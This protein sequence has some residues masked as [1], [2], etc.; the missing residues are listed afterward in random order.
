MKLRFVRFARR[1]PRALASA[2]AAAV[3]LASAGGVVS[4]RETVVVGAGSEMVVDGAV[5]VSSRTLL[6]AAESNLFRIERG[7][8]LVLRNL[9]ITGKNLEPS[10][11]RLAAIFNRGTLVCSNVLFTALSSPNGAGAAYQDRAGAKA[12]FF[13]CS[14]IGNSAADGGAVF[15]ESGD[16]TCVNC[17]FA[18]NH[19][20]NGDG[21]RGGSAAAAIDGAQ[22]RLADCTVTA[23]ES[24]STNGTAM[25]YY[26]ANG[27]LGNSIVA[28]NGPDGY[29][30]VSE[31]EEPV[32]T[33]PFVEGDDFEIVKDRLCLGSTINTARQS[34]TGE[35]CPVSSTVVYLGSRREYT[36]VGVKH[37]WYPPVGDAKRMGVELYADGDYAVVSSDGTGLPI[38]IDTDIFDC[39][40]AVAYMGARRYNALQNMID[41]TPPGGICTVPADVYD[42]AIVGADKTGIVI[43]GAGSASCV[44]NGENAD[45]CLT[46]LA[47][48]VFIGGFN[49]RNGKGDSG[50]GVKS[51]STLGTVVSNCTF[52]GDCADVSG[53][54]VSGV[55][56]VYDSSFTQCEALQNGGGA[57]DVGDVRGC[58]FANCLAGIGGGGLSGAL[59]VAD[60]TFEYCRA[61]NAVSTGGGA[62][63]GANSMGVYTRCVFTECSANDGGALANV[64]EA[65]KCSF[66]KNTASNQGGGV[67]G[68]GTVADGSFLRNVATGGGGAAFCVRIEDSVFDSNGA[69]ENGGG[70]YS[71]DVVKHSTYISNVAAK[72]GGGAYGAGSLEGCV[73]RGNSSVNG[74]G[75][76]NLSQVVGTVFSKNAAT[77]AGGAGSGDAVYR[78]CTFYYNSANSVSVEP[79]S[80]LSGGSCTDSLFSNNVLPVGGCDSAS[81]QISSSY[82]YD[83]SNGDFHLHPGKNQSTYVGSVNGRNLALNNHWT[84]PDK[85][86]LV[87]QYEGSLHYY[88][89]AYAFSSV[90]LGGTV[91]TGPD[92]NYA[93]SNLRTSLREAV[94]YAV[95]S[96]ANRGADGKFLI[97]F[98]DKLFDST[99]VATIS[100]GQSG[101]VLD[102]YTNGALVVRGPADKT[103]VIDGKDRYRP[104]QVNP[105][106]V[107][108]LENIT[109]ENCFGAPYALKG[110]PPTTDGG[111]VLNRGMLRATNC[112]FR[113][114]Q[115]GN[116]IVNGQTGPADPIGNGGALYNASGSTAVVVRCSFV[117]CRAVCGGAVYDESGSRTSYANSTFSGNTAI[118]DSSVKGASGGAICL[119]GTSPDSVIVNC[120]IV[121]NS[122]LGEQELGSGGGVS[123]EGS[124]SSVTCRLVDSIVVGNSAA[125]APDIMSRGKMDLHYTSYG[126]RND[127]TDLRWGDYTSE[128]GMSVA[129]FFADLTADGGVVAR[130]TT[131]G[132][133]TVHSYFPLVTNC[134]A[135][136]AIVRANADYSLVATATGTSARDK[137]TLVRGSSAIQAR[138]APIDRLDQLGSEA[139]TDAESVHIGAVFATDERTAPPIDPPPHVDDPL[140]VTKADPDKLRNAIAYAGGN[141]AS[142]A[143]D[144]RV[145]V[146]AAED[147]LGAIIDF[148]EEDCNVPIKSFTDVTL[149]IRG[150]MTIDL[151]GLGRFLDV[152]GGNRV[153]LYDITIVN[154]AAGAGQGGGAICVDSGEDGNLASRLYCSNCTFTACTAG[155][156]SDGGWGYGGAVSQEGLVSTMLFEDCVFTGN[157]SFEGLG[158]SIYHEG[159]LGVRGCT[160][161]VTD[162]FPFPLY[163][164]MKSDGTTLYTDNVEE[165]VAAIEPDA[166]DILVRLSEECE[167]EDKIQVPAGT[168]VATVPAD[169]I[170]YSSMALATVDAAPEPAADGAVLKMKNGIAVVYSSAAEAM[171]TIAS[172]YEIGD[173]L[174][175]GSGA[176]D[177]LGAAQEIAAAAVEGRDW[178]DVKTDGLT[179]STELNDLAVPVIVSIDVVDDAK[180]GGRVEITPTN[181][182][183]DL[184]YGIGSSDTLDGEFIAIEDSWMRADSSGLLAKPLEAS[185][186]GSCRF[187]RV[188]AKP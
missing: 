175:L 10:D 56:G 142:L 90:K 88:L 30:L 66:Q 180:S 169:D 126:L 166:G 134:T 130:E 181:V 163:A 2:L 1:V 58:S 49:F 182:K 165:A 185:R 117:G 177:L 110:T 101:I 55:A 170:I 107:L 76:C 93:N 143:E 109:F 78:N 173:T 8:R 184:W 121:G 132:L 164:V 80:A 172:I 86:E 63:G 84:D 44:V 97:T 111:C 89:G 118:G 91:V 31:N 16:V 69:E 4:G 140:A 18:E 176:S 43:L 51:S 29:E 9:T 67:Y 146:Y 73:L 95:S 53:G 162:I 82:F 71:C 137:V 100:F 79:E 99:G 83:A 103:V 124:Q 15:V 35:L 17:T 94:E 131:L 157:S 119:A 151:H 47:T 62:Y 149:A 113:N 50:G 21:V 45:V 106:N 188:I 156:D 60:T 19:A 123:L 37:T 14:F 33:R 139:R 34:A 57:A 52:Y 42:T 41:A 24:S 127:E 77:T 133:G 129:D 5:D 27:Y 36:H 96:A 64:E 32:C 81:K 98:S 105:R 120:T 104:F 152:F 158:D 3:A 187:Y 144:G 186:V 59:A 61:T 135:E 141:V 153:E 125:V 87:T 85:C 20:T 114:S 128:G 179:V 54:G 155:A 72:N 154:G 138:S 122:C 147:A 11:G 159:E 115:A 68:V 46:V 161:A 74:G 7:G 48:D 6:H 112:A 25:L 28:D 136:A 92:D 183:A 174:T 26:R 160:V 23:N 75:V 108:E 22:L 168:I 102:D 116:R 145:T 70:T 38:R 13:G 171:D 12:R 167:S 178:F 150:P 65:D 40:A 148:D 39:P